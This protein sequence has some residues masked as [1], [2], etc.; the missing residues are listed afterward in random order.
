MLF[1]FDGGAGRPLEGDERGYAGVAGSL[2]A[3]DGYKFRPSVGG[4]PLAQP[5]YAFR[6]PLLPMILA[7]VHS[8]TGGHPAVLRWACAVL[9]ALAAPLAFAVAAR[10]GGTAA[11]GIAGLAVALWPSHVWLSTR[12]LSEPLDSVV[13]L[14]AADLLLRRK[15]AIGGGALGLAVLCRP[16][17]LIAAALA[18]TVSG[19]AEEK[20]RRLG[21]SG[22]AVAMAVLVVTPWVVRNWRAFGRPLLVTSAGVTLFGGNCP[23]ALE[24]EN[25]GR[26]VEP[27]R[28]WKSIVNPTTPPSSLTLLVSEPPNLGMYG[29]SGLGE[30]KSDEMFAD[31][32]SAWVLDNAEGA[33]R[34]ACWKVV[35]FLDPDQHSEKGDSR[36]KSI[37]GWITWGPVLLLVAAAL[38]L[39]AFTRPPEWW[40]A[41]ALLGGHLA[42]T[43]ITYGDARMRAPIEPA[44]LALLVAPLLA[45]WHAKWTGRGAPA[46]VTG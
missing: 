21:A 28:A 9:G 35:R 26:W 16:G 34:L 23:A 32:A 41:A 2:A 14:A 42:T 7:P 45:G 39:G 22:M 1:A 11:G 20:G 19:R 46:T 25:P 10:I 36:L 6:A 30:A 38:V 37:L 3:G 5:L 15:F 17:G 43:V 44:L 29:W 18:G 31:M 40:M 24:H 13:L 8:V 33:A 27:R 12:V 4:A